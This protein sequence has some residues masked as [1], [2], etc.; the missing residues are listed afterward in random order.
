[1]NTVFAQKLGAAFVY[2]ISLLS[3]VNVAVV[4]IG[5]YFGFELTGFASLEAMVAFI[6]QRAVVCAAIG[7]VAIAGL[8]MAFKYVWEAKK[9]KKNFKEAI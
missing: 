3:T 1:M 4:A 6:S 7:G 5:I 2:V 8:F 9:N